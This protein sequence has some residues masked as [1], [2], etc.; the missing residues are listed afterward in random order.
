MKNFRFLF[1]LSLTLIF[2][3]SDG[4]D[5]DGGKEPP[6]GAPGTELTIFFIN[7]PHAQLDNF[8]KIKHIVDKEKQSKD[9]L[10]VC[11]G[12]IFSGNPVVDN[13]SDKGYPIID[14]MNKTGF[15]VAVLGN[16]EFDYGEA[17]LKKR[18]EQAT[19][20]WVCAN[21][22]MEN[23]GIPQPEPFVT[24]SIADLK[25]SILGLVETNG[26][27]GEVIPSTHPWRVKNLSFTEPSITA[28]NF[29]NV[30][31]QEGADLY[32]A[33]THLGYEGYGNRLGDVQLAQQHPYFDLIIGGHSHQKISTR[34]NNIPV[35]Q[36]GAYLQDLGKIVVEVKNKEIE[37]LSYELIDLEAY[38]EH[39]SN[40]QSTITAYNDFPELEQ[41]IGKA[42]SYHDVEK[43]GCFYTDALKSY[44]NVDVT[45][46]NTGGVR[47]WLDQGD[48]T[49]REIYQIAPFNNGT[50]VYTMTVAEIKSFF[51]GSSSGFF[52]AGIAISQEGDKVVVKDD[53]GVV[54]D[55]NLALTIGLND[56]IP[57]VHDTYFPDDAEVRTLTAAETMIAY[58]TT[59]N[60]TVA[61]SDCNRYFRYHN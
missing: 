8:S 17:V 16:H 37:S 14:V 6:I 15:D 7:D 36:S 50:V 39:D 30:K 26:K 59:I 20:D 2:S 35:Y 57:A 51:K 34:V 44:M 32:I 46:Q 47:Y 53:N 41:V 9:V 52:Y 38:D 19:F 58:L 28:G 5:N 22:D 40:L 45:I 24:K 12:D 33:L 48:I 11:S 60:S 10:L 61:Y 23:T 43:V 21:V 56:Y 55:D 18:M 54:L 13:Y 1:L 27:P 42:D 4:G 49:K 31:T 25:I 29:Q 3:C